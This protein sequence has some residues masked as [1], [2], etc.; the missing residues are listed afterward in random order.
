MKQLFKPFLK[1]IGLYILLPFTLLNS[2]KTVE[3]KQMV[4]YPSSY[5]IVNKV[6]K[7]KND[8][9]VIY[10][11]RNDSL[12]KIVSFYNRHQ[13]YKGKKLKRGMHFFVSIE[14]VFSDFERK[15][16]L[17]PPCNAMMDFRGIPIGK[18][19]KR[20]IDDVWFC[21]ELNGPYLTQ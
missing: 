17:F 7:L 9:Y 1:P 6:K 14:S 3:N 10:A 19:P 4:N 15:N 18:E 2:C 16:N 11:H 8:V 13:A 20:G 21:K 12:F 5:Y